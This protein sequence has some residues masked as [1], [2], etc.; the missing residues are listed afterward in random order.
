MKNAASWLRWVA[1]NDDETVIKLAQ[2]PGA[3]IGLVREVAV[4]KILGE[5]RYAEF[6]RTFAPLVEAGELFGEALDAY[7]AEFKQKHNIPDQD[8][9]DFALVVKAGFLWCCLEGNGD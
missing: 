2:V 4:R 6:E 3:A 9:K 7:L 8:A 5:E 1:D